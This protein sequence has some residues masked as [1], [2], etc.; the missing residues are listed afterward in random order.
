M[1]KINILCVGKIK[2]SYLKDAINEYSK[3]L[4]KYC[5]LSF[6]ELQDSPLPE[7]SNEILE[8]QIKDLESENLIKHIPK[9]SYTIC[10]DLTRK[11]LLFRRI[12]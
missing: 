7:K 3:R 12:C 6:I 8:N 11:K 9:G 10:L 2:E 1:L 4:S 5:N